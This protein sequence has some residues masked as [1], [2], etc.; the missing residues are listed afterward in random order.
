MHGPHGLG[1]RVGRLVLL[2]GLEPVLKLADVGSE[3]KAGAGL[4]TRLL[5]LPRSHPRRSRCCL[6]HVQRRFEGGLQAQEQVQVV[7]HEQ[8]RRD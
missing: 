6:D 2:Q 5:L 1:Q 4:L 3:R 7:V 8:C